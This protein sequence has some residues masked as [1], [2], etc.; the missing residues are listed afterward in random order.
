ML[1]SSKHYIIHIYYISQRRHV[2]LFVTLDWHLPRK[3]PNCKIHDKNRR[4][5]T[6]KRNDPTWSEEHWCDSEAYKRTVCSNTF[7]ILF[8][9]LHMELG[10]RNAGW[11]VLR[12][13]HTNCS[14]CPKRRI[15]N[16]DQN[17]WHLP[18][19]KTL[20]FPSF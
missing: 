17:Y 6:D 14:Q 12:L 7:F 9:F 15:N 2:T 18:A 16:S 5:Q 8:Y 10:N 13:C 11:N 19:K 1:S 3:P 20:S 4:N